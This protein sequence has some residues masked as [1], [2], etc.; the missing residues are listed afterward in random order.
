H[1]RSGTPICGAARPIPG[2]AY[3]VSIMSSMRRLRSASKRSTG[4]AGTARPAW[5]YRTIG[6][7]MAGLRAL[8]RHA[9]PF[10]V[11]G[12]VA[13]HGRAHFVHRVAAELLEHGV[14]EDERHHGLADDGRGGYRADVA[15]LD[16]RRRFLHGRELDRA[17]R[18]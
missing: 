14:R 12:R 15:S 10:G 5:P 8:D 18:L 13:V 3:I 2:A 6:R 7:S 11:A 17:E 1:T 4:A 16:G 9:E